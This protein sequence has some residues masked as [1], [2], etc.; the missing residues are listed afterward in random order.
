[1]PLRKGSCVA[2]ITPMHAD[3]GQIDF[4]SLERLLDF[5]VEQQT[6]NLC[7]LGTTGEASVLSMAERQ[8][9][10]TTAV[11]RV[12]G[13]LP[14]LVGTGTIDPRHVKAM[15]Q[16][17]ADCGC[18]AS[19]LVTP[20]YVKPPQRGLIR[21]AVTAADWGLLPVVLYNVPGRTAVDMTDASVAV[22]AQHERIV[23]LKD[24]TGDLQR[25][26]NLRKLLKGRKDDFLLY[27]G[28]DA[29]SLDFCLRGGDGCISVTANLA[30]RAMHD[31]V[32][33]AC[34]GQDRTMAA[35]SINAQLEFLHKNIFC[36]SNPI[37][38]K[39]ALRR[40]GMIDSAYC[41]PP[42]DELDPKMESL[43]DAALRHAG[44]LS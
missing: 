20:Y 38:T 16:Q 3:T 22:A 5:H 28:D 11:Q 10:L 36:E 18:D 2:L 21:H 26:S 42:L 7:I 27:S 32:M 15:T 39:Y 13:K 29:T 44:L 4:P 30:P 31:L 35:E 17:A 9:V 24:A 19:L 14:I 34:S 37:P 12:K 33:A 41:R 25:V 6:D 40:L 8:A 23:G 1:M 43:V